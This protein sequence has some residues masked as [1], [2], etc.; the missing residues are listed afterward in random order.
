MKIKYIDIQNF[1][2][3]KK[4]RI[5]FS[6]KETLFVGANN[7]GK[8]S[9]MDA[10]ILFLSQKNKIS[11]SD[12]T[13]SNW[14]EIDKIATNWLK[15]QHA[16]KI[17]LSI[18]PWQS[19][20]PS[21]D[22]W[23]DVNQDEVHYV[24]HLIPTLDWDGG[25]LGVRIR[26][27]PENIEKLYQDFTLEYNASKKVIEEAK[28]AN[29][30]INLQI[31]PKNIHDFLN[32]KLHSYFT[33]HAYILDPLKVDQKDMQE[34][35]T[36]SIPLEGS[37]FKGLIKIDIV[38]AQRG[39]SDPNTSDSIDTPRNEGNLSVQ[40][41]EYY[42]KVINPTELPNSSDIEALEAIDNAQNTFD[43]KLSEDFKP[44]LGEV[45]ELGYPGFGNPKITL[46][47]KVNPIDSLN[48]SASVQFE[49]IESKDNNA[50]L[51]LPEKYNGLG[52]QNLI[53]MIFKLIRFRNEWM[54]DGKVGKRNTDFIEPLHLVI[55]EE[56]EAHL[57]AQV[58]QVFINKAYE[59]LRKHQ[60]LKENKQFSTQLIISTH[61]NHIAHE[62]D[63]KNLRYFKRELVSTSTEVPTATV[64]NLSTVFGNEDKTTKFAIRYLQ[65][66]HCDLFFS[67]AVILVEGSAERILIPH[68]IRSHF[69]ELTSSYISILEIGGS[70]A[71]KLKPLIEALGIITLI[72]SD[73]DSIDPADNNKAAVPEKG[74]N[75]K[76]DNSTLKDWLPKEELFDTL[77]NL[78]R[79]DKVSKILP[80]RIAYQFP[81]TISIEGNDRE[82]IPYTFEDALVYENMELFKN[83]DGFG[84]IKKFKTS[85]ND[86]RSTKALGEEFFEILKGDKAKFALDL[87]YIEDPQK[88]KIPTYIEEGMQWLNEKLQERQASLSITAKES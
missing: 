75:Y 23:L 80:I 43:S 59:V 47:T 56:P 61:S 62:V 67:D 69:S 64:V 42:S 1:R 12:F 15:E 78:N 63:F 68:F 85:I 81:M 10:L 71:H 66:T 79:D 52:Y 6:E 7:S 31:W 2:K 41:R 54:K 29:D 16:E 30:K 86:D 74:K 65:T 25:F 55:I 50:F 35:S 53:S 32:K 73:I 72:I 49:V 88:L 39:F 22:I 82:V 33:M 38:N 70:H 11:T 5:E 46:S 37:P 21:I 20:L 58:Q 36:D 24:N 9:A 77:L 40:L 84:M 28:I 34:I 14:F 13:L 19:C 45:E 18:R 26:F 4:C 51:K 60:N 17:D 83:I 87:L 48:H 57:H 8:T 76:T 44:A 3:L 27:E